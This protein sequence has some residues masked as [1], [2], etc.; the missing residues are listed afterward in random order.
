[1]AKFIQTLFDAAAPAGE[2]GAAFTANQGPNV[3]PPNGAYLDHLL[4]SITGDIATAAV[5]VETFM[6]VL[7]QFTLKAG[8]ETRIQLNGNDLIAL[9]AAYYNELPE[10][11]PDSGTGNDWV[12]GI[13]VP[14]QE[15]ISQGTTYTWSATYV[16][17]TNCTVVK[18]CVQAVYEDNANGRRPIIAVP[19]SFTTPGATGMTSINARLQNLGDLVGLLVQQTTVFGNASD[20]WDIQRIQLVENGKQ[21]SLLSMA[22]GTKLLGQSSF[23]IANPLSELLA[24]YSFF[25][26]N[27]SPLNVSD[28]YV[29]FIADVETVSE[30]VRFIPIVLKK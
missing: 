22:N 16:A 26:F 15:A 7:S 17:Q 6:G 27:E 29:E 14:V 18:M 11:G 1:M 9:M 20:V 24:V 12:F 8:Q 3:I 5:P 4:I 25:P 23:G 30:A 28:G 13:K 2:I 21:T 10:S 19:I